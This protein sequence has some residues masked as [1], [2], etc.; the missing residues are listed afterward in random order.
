M[1]FD[2]AKPQF[3]DSHFVIVYVEARFVDA[4]PFGDRLDT[5][6]DEFYIS[7]KR[8]LPDEQFANAFL[9]GFYPAL[10]AFHT[11]TEFQN[12]SADIG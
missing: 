2:A 4:L 6:P 8:G 3:N 1:S 5:F 10:D 7:G 11:A 12:A 9:D